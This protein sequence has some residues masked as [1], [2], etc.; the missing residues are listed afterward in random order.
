[1]L[2]KIVKTSLLPVL[3]WLFAVCS[4][5]QTEKIVIFDGSLSMGKIYRAEIIFDE[6]SKEWGTVKNLKPP[7]HHAARIEW[8]NLTEFANLKK[9]KSVGQRQII[10]KLKEK[11]VYRVN[12][13]RWN[14]IYYCK[15]LRVL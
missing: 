3:L 13:D 4:F 9:P 14:T 1:M 8:V 6:K 7:H 11:K 5:A 10:F 15:I 2:K 12:Q